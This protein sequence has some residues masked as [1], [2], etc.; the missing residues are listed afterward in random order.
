MG[1]GS[2]SLGTT[3]DM[4]AHK[5]VQAVLGILAGQA[6]GQVGGVSLSCATPWSSILQMEHLNGLLSL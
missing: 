2:A 3:M 6:G 1:I 5:L 4:Q